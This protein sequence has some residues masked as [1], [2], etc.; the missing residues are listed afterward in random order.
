MTDKM[1]EMFI[2]WAVHADAMECNETSLNNMA[3][4]S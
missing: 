4:F 3:G 1:E 2:V